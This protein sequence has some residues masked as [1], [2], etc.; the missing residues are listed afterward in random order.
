MQCILTSPD[1]RLQAIAACDEI[2]GTAVERHL[3]SACPRHA[4][5]LHVRPLEESDNGESS[6]DKPLVDKVRNRA[7]TAANKSSLLLRDTKDNI[8]AANGSKI[9]ESIRNIPLDKWTAQ[10]TNN[11]Q[12]S[13]IVGRAGCKLSK[14][15]TNNTKDRELREVAAR[16]GL[17]QSR[18][19]TTRLVDVARS[20]KRPLH[21]A[22]ED[23]KLLPPEKE[24]K[25]TEEPEDTSSG[26]PE[27]VDSWASYMAA[28]RDEERLF[29][30]EQ[31]NAFADTD[32]QSGKKGGENHPNTPNRLALS[33]AEV[34]QS[35]SLS[36]Q[37]SP[38]LY[39]VSEHLLTNDD[40]PEDVFS[41]D[42]KFITTQGTIKQQETQERHFCATLEPANW[43]PDHAG[44]SVA[45]V[46]IVSTPSYELDT[47][48]GQ[49]VPL[50]DEDF[51]R[52]FGVYF[53]DQ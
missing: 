19:D 9:L 13:S 10:S 32:E 6:S 27:I 18:I 29:T 2:A 12:K 11:A 48:D 43:L 42:M 52:L 47:T 33:Q 15:G 1:D 22:S 23:D 3:A 45:N 44:A 50:S 5:P 34:L 8:S 35:G 4:F 37:A 38:T 53:F 14:R 20:H 7:P 24:S 49:S 16:R 21:A 28:S 51:E 17:A 39:A 36:S 30:V 25:V 31:E 40:V 26:S 41:E 46:S